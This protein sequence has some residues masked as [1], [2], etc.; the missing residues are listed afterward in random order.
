MGTF[1]SPLR[2]L[3]G[4]TGER[5]P[6]PSGR[7]AGMRGKGRRRGDDVWEGADG[8]VVTPVDPGEFPARQSDPV[9]RR[10]FEGPSGPGH[11]NLITRDGE[12]R[13][14]VAEGGF[15]HHRNLTTLTVEDADPSGGGS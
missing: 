14:R 10:G 3:P 1:H 13:R 12:L 5:V 6:P 9:L 15:E 2:A 8:V 11:R 7:A 4:D